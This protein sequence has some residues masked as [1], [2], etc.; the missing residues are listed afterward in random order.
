MLPWIPTP[1]GPAVSRDSVVEDEG[2]EAA[3][4]M[5][6]GDLIGHPVT[7]RVPSGMPR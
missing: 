5:E 7:P 6:T 2:E 3:E 1:P 4:A